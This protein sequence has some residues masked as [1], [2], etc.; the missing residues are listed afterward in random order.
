MHLI[1]DVLKHGKTHRTTHPIDAVWCKER[2][3]R[4]YYSAQLSNTFI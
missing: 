3:H 1:R 4:T 2:L